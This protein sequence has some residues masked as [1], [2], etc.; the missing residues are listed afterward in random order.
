[1][2]T[3]NLFYTVSYVQGNYLKRFTL[4]KKIKKIRLWLSNI[5]RCRQWNVVATAFCAV[6]AAR[7]LRHDQVTYDYDTGSSIWVQLA[8]PCLLYQVTQF[9]DVTS[10]DELAPPL[11]ALCSLRSLD[12]QRNWIYETLK[13]YYNSP[14]TRFKQIMNKLP[15]L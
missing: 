7:R 1:M 9:C 3:L 11:P 6:S 10:H 13:P 14:T 2:I 8:L 12:I 4:Y 15:V 5:K